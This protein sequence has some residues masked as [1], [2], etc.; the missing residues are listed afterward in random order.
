MRDR[1]GAATCP[2]PGDPGL[3][4]ASENGEPALLTGHRLAPMETALPLDHAACESARLARDARFD[5]VF[6]TAV[7]STGIYCRPVC[8]APAPKPSNVTYYPTAAAAAAAGFRPCLR[9][10][11]ELAPEAQDAL[12]NETLQRALALIHDGYLQDQPVADLA[13]HVGLSARQ[14]QRLFVARLG[15]APAQIHATRRLLLAKQLLT[16][17]ALP[18]TDVAMASGYNSLRRFNAA[19]LDGCGMPPTAIRRQRGTLTEGALTLRLGY[20]PPL[21]FT[22]MLGFLRRRA[23]PGIEQIDTDSYQRVIGPPERPSLLRVT[24][25]PRRPEL[26]LHLGQV[27]PRAIPGIVRRVRRIFDLDA[28]LRMVHATLA[29]EP[30]L[31]TGIAQ[32]PGLRVPG[33]WDG[34]EVA[35]RA[36]LGQQV[37][38][39]AAATLA[40]R[41]VDRFGA[42]LEGMPEGLD[43]QFPLPEVL[44]QASLET[45]GLPRT[46]AATVRAVAQAVVDGRLDFRAGQSLAGF[47]ARCVAL[48][49]IGPWTAHYM[50]LRAL[51]LPDAFPAGDLVLQQ[52][53]GGDTRLSERATEA[54][55]QPW[56][57]WRA[58]AVLHLWH[59]ATPSS[60]V[61]S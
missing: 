52:V 31:A 60:G 13:T 50:A 45:I 11:P 27:D 4:L 42:T 38:V 34:F 51:A 12:N 37:S 29:Q 55:S 15:A 54:R 59:L 47:V 3:A 22:A 44:A 36:V 35:V 2:E 10:R 58:Y 56:R 40:R 21:D 53:L 46:R 32:R 25:D 18:V 23:I 7:R 41:V 17:T 30:L 43:R 20:R 9:C 57:P 26:L 49:G 16:E 24:A 8:P 28:D 1:H 19:F 5:G 39:A 48:P 6:F 61:T 14:L 33:G